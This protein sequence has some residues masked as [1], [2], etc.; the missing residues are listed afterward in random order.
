MHRDSTSL[1]AVRTAW[2]RVICLWAGLFP[3]INTLRAADGPPEVDPLALVEPNTV[4][5]LRIHSPKRLVEHPLVREVVGLLEK[6]A[7]REP[8]LSPL[9]TPQLTQL[10]QFLELSLQKP[11]DQA[12]EA[13][14]ADNVLLALGRK[15]DGDQPTQL[16]ITTDSPATA[17]GIR[18]ALAAAG[19]A[20]NGDVQR[21]DYR[22][23]TGFR[24]K[25]GHAVF[26]GRRMIVCSRRSLLE[27]LVDRL[28]D[29]S[30]R[31]KW[32]I[33]ERLEFGG[34]TNAKT[35]DRPVFE[36]LISLDEARK[37]EQFSKGLALPTENVLGVL[38]AGGYVDL[39]SRAK[40]VTA[41]LTLEPGRIDF[42][43]RSDAG[44]TGMRPAL[45]DF[46]AKPNGSTTAL[47]KAVPGELLR[48]AWH[49]DLWP[50]YEDDA[51]VL[52]PAT[53]EKLR[54]DSNNQAD[55][56][57]IGGLKFLETTSGDQRLYVTQP[58]EH[59]YRAQ[60]EKRLPGIG[61][62]I[63]LRDEARFRKDCF[64]PFVTLIKSPITA[65]V[66]RVTEE[67][68]AGV[69]IYRAKFLEQIAEKQTGQFKHLLMNYDPSIAIANGEL[70]F[71]SNAAL[72]RK[73]IDA[74]PCQ[75]AS[76]N[77][78]PR[79]APNAG[80]DRVD[81]LAVADFLAKYAQAE[82]RSDLV[83]KNGLSLEEANEEAKRLLEVIRHLA[84]VERT[85]RLE[86]DLFELSHTIGP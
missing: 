51:G 55:A 30:R 45:I 15:V 50:I 25:D 61:W 73:M 20:G 70:L 40:Y 32:E 83:L 22:G 71:T 72:L 27:S 2:L 8:L 39:L 68:H 44:R 21:S 69:K 5:V 42:R 56:G 24:L 62:S 81:L 18:D 11:W 78:V 84:R 66:G 13:I 29:E 65:G 85:T 67:E 36:A 77:S 64:E 1:L 52:A 47:A 9:Q 59:G 35:E 7:L 12:L 38:I 10:K 54:S 63:S 86:P 49:R 60:P 41:A 76:A 33:P 19:L 74:G 28:F 58:E 4:A 57:F 34:P 23:L 75:A 3:G 46:F 53:L 37:D 16:I 26:T 17:S 48:M 31:T 43:L 82:L 79:M 6:S 14:T 80:D